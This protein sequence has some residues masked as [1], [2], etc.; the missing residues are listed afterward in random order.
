MNSVAVSVEPENDSD[1][2]SGGE[3]P[4]TSEQPPT[5]VEEIEGTSVRHP[6]NE[7]VRSSRVVTNMDLI[8]RSLLIVVFILR[9][10]PTMFAISINY[11]C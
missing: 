9:G 1:C 8:M 7:A 10:K 11:I 6:A 5:F 4:P 2:G 3:G